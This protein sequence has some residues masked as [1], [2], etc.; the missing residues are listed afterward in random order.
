MNIYL[1]TVH[2]NRNNLRVVEFAYAWWVALGERSRSMQKDD[3]LMQVAQKH[4]EF[5]AKRRGE[6][7]LQSMHFGEGGSTANERVRDGG[8]D[9]GGLSLVG[10]NVESCSSNWGT[11]T[12]ALEALLL[13]PSHRMHLLGENGFWRYTVYG[14]GNAH[15][16]WV[17]IICPPEG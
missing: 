8:Y 12:D 7:V 6:E 15:D 17:V 9:L 14:I 4:A 3:R 10:N 13:S 11:P 16:Y 1:P 2:G 5:L